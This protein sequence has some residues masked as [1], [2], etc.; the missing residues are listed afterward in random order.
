MLFPI[1]GINDGSASEMD[2][3][4][5][6][7]SGW[8]YYLFLFIVFCEILPTN[9]RV[10]YRLIYVEIKPSLFQMRTRQ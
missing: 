2:L 9:F 5:I 1:K 10:V 8:C 7:A 6:V 3:Y 4:Q